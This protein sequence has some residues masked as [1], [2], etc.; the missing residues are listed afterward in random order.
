MD[1]GKILIT[2]T[3]RCG[4]TF[5]CLIYTLLDLGTEYTRSN[6]SRYVDFNNVCGLETHLN[7]NVNIQARVVKNPEYL[8]QIDEIIDKLRIKIDYVI[9]PIRN[10]RESAESRNKIKEGWGGLTHA[11]NINE[12]M[13]YYDDSMSNYLMSMV[14]YEINTIFIDFY[15]MIEDPIY[16]YSKLQPTLGGKSVSEFTAAYRE[17]G[18]ILKKR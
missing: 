11:S 3:G 8:N 2:G 12:Q 13:L 17:A 4:T 1:S 14:K 9:I 6:F 16:L 7:N 18:E 10:F 5:L 15:K